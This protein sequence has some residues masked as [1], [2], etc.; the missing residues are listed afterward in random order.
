MAFEKQLIA[1]YP[2][3]AS[4]LHDS[5]QYT[6]KCMY[7]IGASLSEPH[8][9]DVNVREYLYIWFDRH[10]CCAAHIQYIVARSKI[11]RT[12]RIACCNV[13][14]LHCTSVQCILPRVQAMR[15]RSWLLKCLHFI[16]SLVRYQLTPL[17]RWWETCYLYTSY[18]GLKET[19]ASACTA[20]HFQTSLRLA[21]QCL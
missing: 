2:W 11:F 8:I 16:A 20:F 3:T 6:K 17:Q 1:D 7:V 9:D 13:C 12:M 18:S 10:P 19:N 14:V 15:F 21:P 5:M 4:F